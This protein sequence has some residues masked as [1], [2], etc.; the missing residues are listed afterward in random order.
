M[1]VFFPLK[2]T[3]FYNLVSQSVITYGTQ[4]WGWQKFV[5][6][7]KLSFRKKNYLIRALLFPS[8]FNHLETK[9]GPYIFIYTETALKLFTEN[10]LRFQIIGMLKFWHFKL[11]K[12]TFYGSN[13]HRIN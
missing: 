6:V 10:V 2:S 9:I 4:I 7:E 5:E 13:A 12:Q 1:N 3:N 8:S 11:L